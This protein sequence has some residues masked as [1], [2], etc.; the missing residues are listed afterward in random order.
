M[1]GLPTVLERLAELVRAT[2]ILV[3]GIGWLAN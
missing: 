1:S 3:L 2:H